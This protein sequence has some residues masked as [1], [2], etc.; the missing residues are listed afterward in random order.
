M[1]K[2]EIQWAETVWY[3]TIIEA[4]TVDEARELFYDGEFTDSD[5]IDSYF[6]EIRMI[7]EVGNN[8]QI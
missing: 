8:E 3:T 5:Q 2:F 6:E 4:D 1:A 7:S